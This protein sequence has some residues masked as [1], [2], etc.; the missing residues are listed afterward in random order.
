ME[1]WEAAFRKSHTDLPA[2]RVFA[3]RRDILTESSGE[4][5]IAVSWQADVGITGAEF[6]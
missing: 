6:S 2:D 3:E 1:D 4:I 5:A